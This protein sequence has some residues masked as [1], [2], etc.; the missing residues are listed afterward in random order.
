VKPHGSPQSEDDWKTE[1]ISLTEYAG[2]SKVRLAFAIT[3][4]NGNNLYLDDIE[5]YTTDKPNLIEIDQ[6]V[7][8]YPNP[9]S[10]EFNIVFNFNI[11]E[12]VLI[13]LT[14][15]YGSIMTE[16]L[17]DNTLNQIYQIKNL[18]LRNGI[19]LLYITGNNTDIAKK[20]IIQ[21]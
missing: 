13:Q 9:A 11:K 12:E 20:V 16:K 1:Y 19:Y 17:F 4:Q 14:D 7:L 3:N 6:T 15:L 2:R 18:S 10:Q 5:F 8:I 21:N